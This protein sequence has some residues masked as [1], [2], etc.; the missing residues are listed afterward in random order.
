VSAPFPARASGIYGLVRLDGAPVDRDEAALLGLAGDS[1]CLVSGEDRGAPASVHEAIDPGGHTVLVGEVEEVAGLAERLNLPPA[2]PL[3]LLARAALKRFGSDLPLILTGEWS[4][5]HFEPPGLLSLSMSAARRDRLFYAVSGGRVAVAPDLFRLAELPWIGTG[6]D[7]AGL[8]FSLG[9]GELRT[10]IGERTM[11][12]RVRQVEPAA[13]LLFT[14]DQVRR[15]LAAPFT[16]QRRWPGSFAD[17]MAEADLLM[18]TIVRERVAR[19]SAPAVMLSGGL[20]SSTLAFLAAEERGPGQP[21]A[22]LTSVAPPGSGLADEAR[23]ADMVADRLGLKVQPVWPPAEANIYRPPERVLAGAGGPPLP[24]RH[25]LTEAFQVAGRALGASMLIDGT[26]G[27]LS[28]TG[29]PRPGGLARLR[30]AA[31]RARRRLAGKASGASI[32]AAFHVRLAPGRLASLPEEVLSSLAQPRRQAPAAAAGLWGYEFGTS[33]AMLHANEFYGGAIRAQFPYR[34]VRLLRLFAAF[35]SSFMTE[36]G[37]DRA[38]ARFIA[39]SHLP[40]EIRLRSSGLPA[41]P[42][43]SQRLRRQAPAALERVAAFRKAGVDEWLDL[44]WLGEALGR[45]GKAGPSDID[46]ANQA[47][48]TA[49]TAEFL[50][51]WRGRS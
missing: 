16:P 40:D 28:L 9:R 18:R 24:T 50:S 45:I 46:E 41:S 20:D 33:K 3:A 38:P 27:E 48:L 15:S 6:L 43:H 23:F 39:R 10:A 25:C 31:G 30:R 36:G 2:A 26:W 34:D 35:P 5:F 42:D 19:S 13:T 7:E 8:L 14:M 49:I 22:L 17:A 11:L 51:W 47:Q 37:L 29:R 12:G 32:G 21:L 44:D 1:S 4:L